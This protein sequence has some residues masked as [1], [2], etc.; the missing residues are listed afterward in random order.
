MLM[1]ANFSF[2]QLK[3][4]LDNV[5]VKFHIYSDDVDGTIGGFAAKIM[6]DSENFGEGDIS[7]SV[8]ASTIDTG[9]KKRDEHLRSKD[10]FDVE[11]YPEISFV[12][13]SIT[14]PKDKYV[15]TGDLTMMGITKEIKITF[16]YV[17]NI[18]MAKSYI[19]G[20]DFEIGHNWKDR[21][22]SKIKIFWKIPII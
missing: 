21:A 1:V 13:K 20:E 12:S 17:D 19:Y 11:K 14:K 5:L 15:M 10:Y 16:T 18:F 9:N 8:D 22:D 6:F 4:K 3:I 2:G 7:G